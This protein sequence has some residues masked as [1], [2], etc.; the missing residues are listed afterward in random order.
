MS[1]K[2]KQILTVKEMMSEIEDA[3]ESVRRV[4]NLQQSLEQMVR[5]QR[6]Y[7]LPSDD[8]VIRIAVISDIHVGSLYFK[9]NALATF[10]QAAEAAGCK[11]VFCS[12]DILAGWKVYKGQEFELRDRGIDEQLSRLAECWP[13]TQMDTVFITGNHDSSFKSLVG[14]NVGNMIHDR[15]PNMEF[16]GEDQ[17][18]IEIG[19][20]RYRVMMVHPG[21]GTAYA[22]SYRPQKLVE[23]LSGGKKP[24]MLIVGHYHKAEFIPAYR[25]VAILQA[26]T[27]ESQTP[28][29]TRQGISAHLGGWIVEIKMG[30]KKD[31]CNSVKAQFISFYEEE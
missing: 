6:K 27:F 22:L 18:S 8:S 19:Q 24:N 14:C 3:P 31:L 1:P 16:I 29:M 11:K 25:N 9:P 4:Q 10:F 23:S 17:A 28:F 26:G 15:V 30:D 13:K 20:N 7:V 5:R 12:G 21:G 2:S